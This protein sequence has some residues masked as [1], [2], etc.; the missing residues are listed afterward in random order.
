MQKARRITILLSISLI[1]ASVGLASDKPISFENGI[2]IVLKEDSSVI[3]GKVRE[4][5]PTGIAVYSKKEGS[6][7]YFKD[8]IDQIYYR[9]V[10]S[11]NTGML[12][13]FLGLFVGGLI[14]YAIDGLGNEESE[15]TPFGQEP[16]ESDATNMVL[17]AGCAVGGALISGGLGSNIG[18]YIKVDT[19]SIFDKN[20][21]IFDFGLKNVDHSIY[22]TVRVGF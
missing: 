4:I 14:G 12:C 22:L 13:A 6:R 9:E 3:R 8:Q 10:P 15:N 20:K 7:F 1:I 11:W 2:K 16:V 19:E 21:R 17:I 5:K 18:E